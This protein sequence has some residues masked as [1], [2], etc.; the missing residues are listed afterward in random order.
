MI[1]AVGEQDVVV[2]EAIVLVACAAIVVASLLTDLLYAVL[3]PRI[4]LGS[5]SS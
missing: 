4:R 2:V 1:Q 3:D 5:P